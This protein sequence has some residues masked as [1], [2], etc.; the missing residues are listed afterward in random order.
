[1][2]NAAQRAALERGLQP[3]QLSPKAYWGRGKA[4]ANNGEPEKERS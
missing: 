2:V 1:V 4:N 3:E